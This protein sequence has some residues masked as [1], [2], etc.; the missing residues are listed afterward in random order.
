M[1]QSALEPTPER[2]SV[3]PIGV[4]LAGG[5]GRRMGGAKA[6]VELAGRPLICYPLEALAAALD[7]VAVL[8]KADTELPSLPGATIWVEPQPHHH[9]LVGISQALALAGG[10]PV[11]VCAVDL[12]LVTPELVRRL[13]AEDPGGAPAVL[14]SSR[15]AVQPLL[16]CYRPRALALLGPALD[17]PLRELVAAIKPRLLEVDDPDVLLN[18]NEPRELPR[19]AAA[20]ERRRAVRGASRT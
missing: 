16:G 3:E 6:I 8:A 9:P 12:P 11:L 13:A 10:R 20:L 5:R 2:E 18:V 15:G 17:R 19:A 7:E 4:V 14:A 1:W